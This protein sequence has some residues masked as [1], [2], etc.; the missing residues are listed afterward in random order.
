ME[1]ETQHA[2]R[3]RPVRRAKKQQIVQSSPE[4]GEQVAD[5]IHVATP[6][7]RKPTKPTKP[8]EPDPSQT[9]LQPPFL[10][11]KESFI[12]SPPAKDKPSPFTILPG[13]Q[14][15]IAPGPPVELDTQANPHYQIIYHACALLGHTIKEIDEGPESPMGERE[16]HQLVKAIEQLNQISNKQESGVADDASRVNASA[17]PTPEDPKLKKTAIETRIVTGMGYYV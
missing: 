8:L 17:L 13:Y 1:E 4:T 9:Q 7:V 3:P 15:I 6:A 5:V 16:K 11:G 10:P 2:L 12:C 14:K